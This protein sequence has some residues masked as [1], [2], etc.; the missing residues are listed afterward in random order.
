MIGDQ[1][2]IA[3][4]DGINS[5]PIKKANLK[6]NFLSDKGCHPL[7]KSLQEKKDLEELDLSQNPKISMK[8]Y[9]ILITLL[10]R[11]NKLE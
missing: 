8:S 9:E 10:E 7:L 1:Y 2:A 11:G 6:S 5:S 3:I 4:A